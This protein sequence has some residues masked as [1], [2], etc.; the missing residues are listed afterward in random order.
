VDAQSYD[1]FKAETSAILGKLQGIANNSEIQVIETGNMPDD[2]DE[3][4]QA[5]RRDI[6]MK[7]ANGEI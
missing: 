2:Y 5:E 6:V 3:E 7:R 4:K 1:S